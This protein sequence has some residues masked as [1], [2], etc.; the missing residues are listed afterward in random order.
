M[1][2]QAPNSWQA[3]ALRESKQAPDL[4][5]E[6]DRGPL[7]APYVNPWEALQGD[8]LAVGAD[9]RLR[10]Q[11]LWRRNREGDLAVP[12]VWPRDLAPL[13]WPLVLSL[14]LLVVVAG[15]VEI[16][17][18]WPSRSP[19]S[20]PSPA[21]LDGPPP[22]ISSPMAPEPDVPVIPESPPILSP[23]L[24]E[25]SLSTA[26]KSTSSAP[27]LVMEE[28]PAELSPEPDPLLVMVQEVAAA[29]SDRDGAVELVVNATAVPGRNGVELILSERWNGLSHARREQW[30]AQWW[31]RLES[32]GY[33]E[34]TL[35]S[36]QG[37]TLARTAR[38]GQGMV[39]L[40]QSS[41]ET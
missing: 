39:L 7:P 32:A 1:P 6:A 26:D 12:S 37:I 27:E 20:L 18:L 25:P 2:D 33:S 4:A 15:S 21:V 31:Q 41:A 17:R 23:S 16:V 22:A 19:V 9:L 8:L 36:E 30:A 38:V 3:G 34:L 14:A 5:A 29:A 35:L 10:A 40:D 28:S 11:E 13:F 24:S